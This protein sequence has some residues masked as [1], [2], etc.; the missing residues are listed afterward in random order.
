M[1]QP[2][3][4]DRDDIIP[5]N[6]LDVKAGDATHAP[7][8]LGS[9]SPEARL[10]TALVMQ[11]QALDGMRRSQ[12]DLLRRLAE[13]GR[14]E[15]GPLRDSVSRVHA[16]LDDMREGQ[17]ETA[18]ELARLRR[19]HAA[20]RL[21]MLVV[22]LAALGGAAWWIVS[23]LPAEGG[24][25]ELL[26]RLDAA[27][28]EQQAALT[29]AL[30]E[31]DQATARGLDEQGRLQAALAGLGARI[32]AQ[33]RAA[34]AALAALTGERD[35]LA[36]EVGQ[37]RAEIARLQTEL[38]AR[39]ARVAELAAS[40]DKSRTDSLVQARENTRLRNQ[41][42]EQE[43]QRTELLAT[44][45]QLRLQAETVAPPPVT[46]STGSEAESLAE[47]L[48]GALHSGGRR[49]ARLVEV[50]GLGDGMLTGVM[51]VLL[52]E[53]GEPAGLLRAER[54][55]LVSGPEG[56]ALRLENPAEAIPLVADI[57]LPDTDLS[58]WE[59]RGVTLP[60]GSRSLAEAREALR[61]LLAPFDLQLL[62]L[63]GVEGQ[64]LHGLLLRDGDRRLQAARAEFDP[65]TSAL[66]LSDGLVL[67]A[68]ESRPFFQGRLRLPLAGLS[69]PAWS[70]ALGAAGR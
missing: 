13:G 56:L 51:L 50:A 22:L 11:A 23:S 45:E 20:G 1:N 70:A 52:D 27:R 37:V 2:R 47:R 41:L 30:D 9:L 57:A 54:A 8:D 43:R 33:D 60:D 31:L 39:D 58:A 21:G 14:G 63:A 62:E 19:R 17:Q 5:L 10:A 69:A 61:L 67:T 26:A 49:D 55:R 42:V 29:T 6:P 53:L 28:S 36:A 3:P 4:D 24:D 66:V 16:R 18:E 7:L 15:D 35:A 59:A 65:A 25:P 68:G 44:L 48:N 32:D 12:D 46:T 38:A 40:A 64:S 34:E